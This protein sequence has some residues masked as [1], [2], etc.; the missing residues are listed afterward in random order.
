[1]LRL[2]LAACAMAASAFAGV[3]TFSVG[4]P[5]AAQDFRAKAA[6]FVF[7]MQGCA[8]PEKSQISAAAEGLVKGVRRSVTLNVQAMSKPGVYAV[9]QNWP[10]EGRWVVNLKG[11]C[12]GANAG[13]II[14]IGPKG[15][16]RESAKFFP[17]PASN[18][19]VETS[20]RALA[21]SENKGENK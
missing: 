20:L 9:Y 19:E 17:R 16:V 21:Q 12:N 4:S 11:N 5:V 14:P 10:A 6:A 2:G 1:M 15:F 7:R 8:D 18:V 3:F 13:A